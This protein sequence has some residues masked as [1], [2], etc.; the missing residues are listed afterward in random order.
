MDRYMTIILGIVAGALLIA[1]IAIWCRGLFRR[2]A[3]E[4]DDRRMFDRF[5]ISGWL[6]LQ[7][8]DGTDPA[9]HVKPAKAIEL[10][11]FGGSVLV[12]DT[13]PV[14]S[15][16]YFESRETLMAG[17]AKVKRCTKNRGDYT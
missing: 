15:L 17:F 13:V 10:N 1:V 5:G 14:G 7:W 11:R 9:L 3:K 12:Q 16:I 6:V 4:S 2:N 8:Y